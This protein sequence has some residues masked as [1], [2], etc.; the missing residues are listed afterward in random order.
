M[1]APERLPVVERVKTFRLTGQTPS[2]KVTVNRTVPTGAGLGSAR[3]ME[4]TMGLF[5]ST[6]Y[7]LPVTKSPLPA[8]APPSGLRL[9]SRILSLSTS[10]NRSLPSPVPVS[11]VTKYSLPK[12]LTPVMEAPAMPS[13]A[14]REKSSAL[15]PETCS[16]KITMNET[17]DGVG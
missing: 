3:V 11:T 17:L 10:F 9:V 15:T 1:L 13:S 5:L 8:P 4:A 2:E 6:Q 16:E 12:P 7:R 14:S